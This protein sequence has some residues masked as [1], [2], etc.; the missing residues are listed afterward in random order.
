MHNPYENKLPQS[1]IGIDLPI[2]GCDIDGVI[3]NFTLAFTIIYNRIIKEDHLKLPKVDSKREPSTW[4]ELTGEPPYNKEVVQKLWNERI[5]EVFEIA[6]PYPEAKE[7]LRE[8]RKLGHINFI[9]SQP[10]RVEKQG[11]NDHWCSKH[12]RLIGKDSVFYSKG[13][14]KWKLCNILIDDSPANIKAAYENKI[15]TFTVAHR[16]NRDVPGFRGNWNQII[17]ELKRQLNH[18][19][20]QNATT[21]I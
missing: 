19:E 3:R 16:Y 13:E 21:S 10:S 11:Y 14:E 12:W 20:N 5:K 2:I 17:V 6:Q 9:T 8:L 18:K 15:K 1:L 7:F 4:G